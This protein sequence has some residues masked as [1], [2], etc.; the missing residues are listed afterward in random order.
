MVN[1]DTSDG[2]GMAP[3]FRALAEAEAAL[4]LDTPRPLEPELRAKYDSLRDDLIH[5]RMRANALRS[6]SDQ[7]PRVGG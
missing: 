4:S 1:I 5:I 7:R 3:L 2:L 6:A